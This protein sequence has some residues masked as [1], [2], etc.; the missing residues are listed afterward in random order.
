MENISLIC[1]YCGGVLS[2]FMGI[3]HTQFSRLFKWKREFEKVSDTNRK[4]IYTV[5]IALLLLFFGIAVVS[6]FYAKELSLCSGIS[7]GINLMIAVFWLWRTVWQIFYFKMKKNNPLHFVLIGY[8][9]LL[10]LS[11][12]FPVML[13]VL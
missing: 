11:Y 5:N 3:F 9:A 2:I 7:F 10:F 4:I 8:F 1:I 12:A 6:L 13:K